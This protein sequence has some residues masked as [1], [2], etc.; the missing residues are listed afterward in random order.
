LSG[1]TISIQENIFKRPDI[2]FSNLKGSIILN[3]NQFYL[4]GK[5]QNYNSAI[6]LASGSA[7]FLFFSESSQICGPPGT[8]ATFEISTGEPMIFTLSAMPDNSDTFTD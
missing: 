2:I 8:T 5:L 4:F 6:S 7:G 3:A 1:G